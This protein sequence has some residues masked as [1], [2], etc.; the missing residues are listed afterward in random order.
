MKHSVEEIKLAINMQLV[1]MNTLYTFAKL[2][3]IAHN[4]IKKVLELK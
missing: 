2:Y 1:K 4:I 3:I